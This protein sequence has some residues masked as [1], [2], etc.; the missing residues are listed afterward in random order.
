MDLNVKGLDLEV[1]LKVLPWDMQ[2][3]E[4]ATLAG[5]STPTIRYYE[6]IGL[7]P[8]ASRS[9]AGYRRYSETAVEELRFIRKAQ[10]LGFSLD[11]I[12]TI[13][14]LS[15]SGKGPCGEVLAL[16]R[17][18][19]HAVEERIQQLQAFRDQLAADIQKWE[20]EKTA[21]TCNG[22]CRWIADSDFQ[23]I[24]APVVTGRK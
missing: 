3:S 1:G 19:V 12:R 7:L 4:A 2:I 24:D 6:Q 18:H 21:V 13:L 11:E 20:A 10:A 5:V 9:A 8:R 14:E 15:R 23:S 16:A 17:Q 22:L